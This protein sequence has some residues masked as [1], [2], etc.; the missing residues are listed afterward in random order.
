MDV[1]GDVDVDME[2]GV[3]GIR[4]DAAMYSLRVMNERNETYDDAVELLHGLSR[5]LR[6]NPQLAMGRSE[7]QRLPTPPTSIVTSI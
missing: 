4:C 1:D 3:D 2:V 5:F 7:Y 6:A